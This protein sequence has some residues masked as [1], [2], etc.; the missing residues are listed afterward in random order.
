M[1]TVLR[2]GRYRFFFY[3]NEGQEPAHVHVESGED[4]AKFRPDPVS[5]SANHGFN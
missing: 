4:M 2:I 1:P 3:S 5:L